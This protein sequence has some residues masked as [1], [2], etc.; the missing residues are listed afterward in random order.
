[1]AEPTVRLFVYNAVT[2]AKAVVDEVITDMPQYWNEDG[3]G[4]D[5]YQCRW[6]NVSRAFTPKGKEEL[7]KPEAHEEGCM[8]RVAMEILRDY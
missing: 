8:Y 5:M 3:R 1:M 7:L 2:L 6:C 4:N